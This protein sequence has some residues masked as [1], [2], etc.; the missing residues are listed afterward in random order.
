[1]KTEN[2]QSLIDNIQEKLGDENSNLILDDL[3][4]IISDNKEMNETITS[5]DNDIKKLQQTN[6]QIMQ[7]NSKLFQQIPLENEEEKSKKDEEEKPFSFRKM[8]DEKGNFIE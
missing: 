1:M 3:V 5:K 2:M 8:F 7:V 6:S 4:T